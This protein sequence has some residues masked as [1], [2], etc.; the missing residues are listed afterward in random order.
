MLD[1]A[2]PE[3]RKIAS[4]TIKVHFILGNYKNKEKCL[5]TGYH[6]ASAHKPSTLN[7]SKD[8]NME[9]FTNLAASL[10]P[11]KPRVLGATKTNL[12]H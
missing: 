5:W 11:Q 10:Q 12:I 3:A 6:P 1:I 9:S 2:L 7:L 8:E 4:P